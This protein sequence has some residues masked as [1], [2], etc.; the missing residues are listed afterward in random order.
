M[1]DNSGRWSEF[2]NPLD[3]RGNSN[4]DERKAL[5][6]RFIGLFGLSSIDCI[7]A[8]REF[9][10]QDWIAFLSTQ[11]IKFYIRLRENLIVNQRGKSLKAYWLFNNLPL[12]QVR[13]IDKPLKINDQWVYLTGTKILNSKNNI[14]FIIVATYQ[15]DYQ[16]MQI[17]A[18][19]WSIECFFKAIKSSGF[20]IE[21]THITDQMRLEKLFAVVCIAFVWVYLVGQYQNQIK[22]IPVLKHLRRAFS[23]FRYGLDEIN[24]TLLFDSQL[25]IKYSKLLTYT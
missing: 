17:Y 12:N 13:K 14:E 11:S 21:D 19:R 7:I 15:F 24:R 23:I 6:N 18:E 5:I 9:I 25:L 20:N 1:L 16:T 4:Q 3:K 10:G 8:D 22:K 2:A